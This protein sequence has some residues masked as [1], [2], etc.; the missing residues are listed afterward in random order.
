M[1]VLDPT[2]CVP[3]C[4]KACGISLGSDGNRVACP[5]SGVPTDMTLN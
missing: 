4:A 2:G 3:G 5:D 1:A